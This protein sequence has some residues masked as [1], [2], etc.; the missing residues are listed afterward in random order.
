MSEFSRKN[1]WE[2]VYQ[3][4]KTNEVSWYQLNPE[5]SIELILS[6]KPDKE[7]SIIDIGGGDSFLADNLIELGF[8]KIFVLDISSAALER[9]RNRLYNK[10]EYLNCLHSDITDFKTAIRFNIWHDRATFHFL[11]DNQDVKKYIEATKEYIKPKG[12]MILSTFST[13][14]PNKCSGLEVKQYS[15]DSIRKTFL[16]GFD[17]VK[18]LEEVHTTPSSVKQNFI[19]CLLQ[20]KEQ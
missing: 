15:E 6:L 7:D 16:N 9:S 12:Y 4:K 8:K 18:S 5:T 11:T 1:H 13:S 17:F 20:R 14:G 10:K 19:Y 3:K 2:K